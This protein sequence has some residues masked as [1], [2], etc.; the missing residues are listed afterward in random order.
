MRIGAPAKPTDATSAEFVTET[1]EYDG[2]R[3]VT[4]YVPPA[5]PDAIVFAGDD[6]GISKWGR[7]LRTGPS[8]Q[9]TSASDGGP[10]VLLD[11]FVAYRA[12][13]ASR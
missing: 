9:Q 7:L 8:W 6:Q 10:H 13:A 1:F 4:V 11:R 12:A 3:Q 5:P 2:R